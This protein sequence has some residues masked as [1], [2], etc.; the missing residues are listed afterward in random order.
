MQ[1]EIQGMRVWDTG[2]GNIRLDQA[3][4]INMGPLSRDFAFNV[5][6]QRVKK[7]SNSLVGWLKHGTKYDPL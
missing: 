7:V 1:T 4:F 2:G 6:A 5:A 3:T